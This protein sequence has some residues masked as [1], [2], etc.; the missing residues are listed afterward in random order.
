MA[1]KVD[2]I[3][4]MFLA[5]PLYLA[6]GSATAPR[7][8]FFQFNAVCG[9]NLAKLYGGLSMGG[10]RPLLQGILDPP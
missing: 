3:D 7:S 9:E 8:T 6:I 10:R 1:A 2:R 4:F 5:P